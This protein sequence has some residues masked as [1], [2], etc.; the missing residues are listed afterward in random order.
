MN[1]INF[2]VFRVKGIR[3]MGYLAMIQK[4]IRTIYEQITKSLDPGVQMI[5]VFSA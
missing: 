4:E 3:V 2:F 1:D 5:P